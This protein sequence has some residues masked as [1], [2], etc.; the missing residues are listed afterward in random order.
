MNQF[1][2]FFNHYCYSH[3]RILRI[4]FFSIN[5]VLIETKTPMHIKVIVLFKLH[6]YVLYNWQVKGNLWTACFSPR[7]RVLKE[8][9]H[10]LN[11]PRARKQSYFSISAVLDI[12]IAKLLSAIYSHFVVNEIMF[13]TRAESTII[14][15]LFWSSNRIRSGP[16]PISALL[17]LKM[18]K[19]WTESLY[20]C[21][22]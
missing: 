5:F 18:Y 14:S 8:P 7:P 15:T 9:R 1:P 20:K 11:R 4:E 3:T 22:L 6:F 10:S 13:Q 21:V 12:H 19:R 17:L 16:V 2:N